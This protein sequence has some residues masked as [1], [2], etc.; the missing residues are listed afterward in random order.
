MFFS[1]RAGANDF[2]REYHENRGD[3]GTAAVRALNE[4]QTAPRAPFPAR[5]LLITLPYYL[6]V[7]ERAE[8]DLGSWSD[9]DEIGKRRMIRCASAVRAARP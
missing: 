6:G 4:Q 1:D 9:D 8:L 2:L 3:S 7:H 5:L